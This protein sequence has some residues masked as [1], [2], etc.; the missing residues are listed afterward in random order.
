[1][2]PDMKMAAKIARSAGKQGSRNFT[3]R[4]RREIV[5]VETKRGKMVPLRVVKK[6]ER[7]RRERI[8]WLCDKLAPWVLPLL[9]LVM[10][11]NHLLASMN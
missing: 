2:P 1:M 6:R 4:K 5:Y 3:M 9:A 11:I 10:T 8:G 7:A